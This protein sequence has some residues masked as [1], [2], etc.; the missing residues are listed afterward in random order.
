MEQYKQASFVLYFAE[1]NNPLKPEK[2]LR[3]QRKA[4]L[5]NDE[6]CGRKRRIGGTELRECLLKFA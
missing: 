2:H 4:K 6:Q 5:E 1:I 3:M